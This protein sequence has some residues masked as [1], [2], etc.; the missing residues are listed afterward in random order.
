[1]K[2]KKKL[3][4]LCLFS[5]ISNT[6]YSQVGINTETPKATL[7][8]VASLSDESIPPGIIAP[9][10]SRSQLTGISSNYSQD[11]LGSIIYITDISGDANSDTSNITSIGYYYYNGSNWLSISNGEVESPW[12]KV[13]TSISSTQNTDNSFLTAKAVIGGNSIDNINGGTSNAQLTVTGGDASING[14]TVGRGAGASLSNTTIG[15]SS[16]IANTIGTNNTTL[17]S[18]TGTTITTGSN[19]LVI[20]ANAD[21]IS[22]TSSNQINIANTL[23]GVAGNSSANLGRASIGKTSPDTGVTFDVNG[24]TQITGEKAFRYVDGNQAANKVLVSDANG[25]AVWEKVNALNSPMYPSASSGNGYTGNLVKGINSGISITLPAYSVWVV[26]LGQIIRFS[27]YLKAYTNTSGAIV[28]ESVWARLVWSDTPTGAV[29]A[30]VLSGKLISGACYAGGEF[31][32]IGGTS[33]IQNDS[34]QEKTYYLTTDDAN[35]YSID[36]SS[37]ITVEGLFRNWGE[38]SLVVIPANNQNLD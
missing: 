3:F 16:L 2:N 26:E 24:V 38:N 25:N 30:D 4:Y 17:G 8:I 10:I 14:I 34:D 20:G 7:D 28:I 33:V 22:G 12:Y 23:F 35:L 21:V 6:S 11:Q 32:L 36:P 5:I 9:R 19:N 29:S 37:P 18:N 13:G 27:R 15:A 1:M 31:H